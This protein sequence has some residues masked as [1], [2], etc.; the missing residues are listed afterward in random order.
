MLSLFGFL[1]VTEPDGLRD[2]M[3]R[4]DRGE[5]GEDDFAAWLEQRSIP[6]EPE[7]E[8]TERA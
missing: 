5:M 3:V 1:L 7:P 2:T 8:S 6:E 4:L